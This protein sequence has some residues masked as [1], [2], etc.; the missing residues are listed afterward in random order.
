MRPTRR[1]V[2]P[3]IVLLAL[4]I[5]FTAN[6][7]ELNADLLKAAEEGKTDVVRSLIAKG[8]DVNAKD[9]E[10]KTALAYAK[11]NSHTEIVQLLKQA[12]ANVVSSPHKP[13]QKSK[14]KIKFDLPFFRSDPKLQTGPGDE[15]G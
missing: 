15:G 10:G 2:S 14:S 11:E 13:K 8:A 1:I 12:G 5:P 3:L 4:L 7:G 9:K 6:A